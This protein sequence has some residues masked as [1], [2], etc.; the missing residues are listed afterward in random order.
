MNIIAAISLAVVAS[1]L[2]AFGTTLQHTSVGLE[3]AAKDSQS[4]R[5]GI[6]RL[7]ALLRNRRWLGGLALILGGA[8]MHIYSLTLAP[9]TVIQPI[10]ILAVAWSV[11]LGARLHHYRPNAKIWG[12]VA[13][14]VGGIVGFTAL[15]AANTTND[16]TVI[17]PTVVFG[18]CA[19]VYA[20]SAVVALL[21]RRGPS[22]LRCMGWGSA[23]AILYGLTSAQLK[24]MTQLLGDP[25]VFTSPLFWGCV[26]TLIPAYVA[27][28]WMIQQ[29][30]AAGPAEV[31][32][33]SMTTVDP[34]IAVLFGIIV[35]G[36]G[37]L[38]TWPV[39]LAM[40]ATGAVATLGVVLL[41]RHH[42]DAENDS[43]ISRAQQVEQSPAIQ[44]SGG[45]A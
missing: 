43:M 2:F 8:A 9:V 23:G 3:I 45:Q 29:G 27:G 41:S 7:L 38:I 15:S 16:Q 21:A 35:L 11:L 37:A 10:G 44:H 5:I 28:G 22:W 26:A 32:V 14:T 13:L 31:V 40:I 18:A 4:R 25:G 39:A 42:P 17:K 30:F 19:V 24:T 6:T 20:L 36:E 34:L 33:G 12:S 1:V